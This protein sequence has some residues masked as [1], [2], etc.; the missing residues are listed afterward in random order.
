MEAQMDAK[1]L[2]E[3]QKHYE[4][5]YRGDIENGAVLL[6]QSIGIIKQIKKVPDII[7]EVVKEAEIA[8]KRVSSLSRKRM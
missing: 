4:L 8:I 7:Q 3:E 1:A 2:L 6:G 5:T